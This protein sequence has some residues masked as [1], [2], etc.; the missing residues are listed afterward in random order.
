VP[1]LAVVAARTWPAGEPWRAAAAEL[2]YTGIPWLQTARIADS[3]HFVMLDHP[4]QLARLIERFAD[5]PM[6]ELVAAH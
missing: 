5:H 3:G 2:G 6:P 4:E 1:V